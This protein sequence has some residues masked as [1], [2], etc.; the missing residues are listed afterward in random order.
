M[1]SF[2]LHPNNYRHS[3]LAFSTWKFVSSS[4]GATDRPSLRRVDL[5]TT[6]F[7]STCDMHGICFELNSSGEQTQGGNP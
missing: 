2:V 4:I 7:A 1:F 3:G 5:P 6:I